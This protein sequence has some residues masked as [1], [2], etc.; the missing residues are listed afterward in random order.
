M[1]N[2]QD[3]DLVTLTE[4]I[5][6]TNKITNQPILLRRGQIGTVVMSF[7][8]K[9]FLIDFS[10]REGKTFAMET[11][12]NSKLLRLID[13]PELEVTNAYLRK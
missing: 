2:I 10:D 7:D 8:Q 9:A 13:E 4:D 11:V 5:N 6:A 12:D 3:Y 1:N